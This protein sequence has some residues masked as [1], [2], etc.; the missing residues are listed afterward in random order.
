VEIFKIK[1]INFNDTTGCWYYHNIL[2]FKCY[3]GNFII[4]EKE[5]DILQNIGGY[6]WLVIGAE[7]KI[8]LLNTGGTGP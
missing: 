1:Q 3:E 5:E 7:G 2:G 4:K 8:R 6:I